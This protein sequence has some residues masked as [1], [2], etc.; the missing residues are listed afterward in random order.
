MRVASLE[1]LTAATLLAAIG[2]YGV[3]SYAVAQRTQEIGIRVALGAQRREVMGLMLRDSVVMTASGVALGLAAAAAF[4]SYLE[5]MLFA[6]APLDPATFAAV[7]VLFTVVSLIASYVPARRAT[8]V[9]PLVA[10]RAE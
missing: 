3:M 10:L 4:T 1:V 8:G 2:L 9:D 7:T 5:G 6:L